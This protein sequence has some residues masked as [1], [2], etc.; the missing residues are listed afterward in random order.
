M[1]SEPTPQIEFLLS[2][3]VEELASIRAALQ[4]MNELTL[5]KGA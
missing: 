3:I 4:D 5:R 2:A 1:G